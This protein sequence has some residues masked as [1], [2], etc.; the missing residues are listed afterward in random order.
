VALSDDA[1]AI[2]PVSLVGEDSCA[3]RGTGF[4]GAYGP[5]CRVERGTG[6]G[7]SVKD[8]EAAP[9]TSAFVASTGVTRVQIEEKPFD[10]KHTSGWGSLGSSAS[11]GKRS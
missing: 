5:V 10:L 8:A 9:T 3:N 6:R 7:R 1:L 2:A 11:W 4:V